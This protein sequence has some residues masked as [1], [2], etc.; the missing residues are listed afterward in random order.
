MTQFVSAHAGADNKPTTTAKDA[1]TD[2]HA[3][4]LFILVHLRLAPC[5]PRALCTSAVENSPQQL[6]HPT[7][8]VNRSQH[9]FRNFFCFSFKRQFRRKRTR[10]ECPPSEPRKTKPDDWLGAGPVSARG[11]SENASGPPRQSVWGATGRRL[12][13]VA[14]GE[15]VRPRAAPCRGGNYL[16]SAAFLA[17]KSKVPA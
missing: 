7:H 12:P 4:R 15:R 6:R 5:K 10:P 14:G 11:S 17:E 2:F 16:E 9:N 8:G 1:T 3:L 13:S